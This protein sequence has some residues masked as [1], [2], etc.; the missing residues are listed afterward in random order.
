MNSP[1]PITRFRM[2]LSFDGTDYFG[3]QRLGHTPITLQQTMEE[4]LSEFFSRSIKVMGCGRT[5]SGVHAEAYHA[6]FDA[7]LDPARIPR[8]HDA[9]QK[10]TPHTIAVRRIW[11]APPEFHALRD[12]TKKTYKYRIDNRRIPNVFNQR[13]FTHVRRPLDVDFL[14]EA[15]Q[16][17]LG[18]HDFKSFQSS[19]STPKSSDREI[20]EAFW[21]TDGNGRIT[22]T[23]TGSGFLKQM[24]RNIVGTLL[25]MQKYA[26]KPD[27]VLQ[28]L[29]AK[30]RQAAGTTAPP[31][32]LTL[33]RVYYPEFL[34]NECRKI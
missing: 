15:S 31:Q 25:D 9:L 34:D 12:V 30:S 7:P 8:L 19:G 33:S 6:H 22:F 16:F 1:H 28:V 20:L 21:E 10:L 23:I 27:Y 18:Y 24:V 13:F 17:I 14:N 4:A 5:D 29:A 32:G 3:W 11:I 2:C 26:R